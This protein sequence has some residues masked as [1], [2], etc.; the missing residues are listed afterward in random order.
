MI[1]K[2]RAKTRKRIS[3]P[4]NINVEHHSCKERLK[5]LWPLPLIPFRIVV[6]RYPHAS[7]FWK[8]CYKY[9]NI[10]YC[11]WGELL[12]F[13]CMTSIVRSDIH[14]KGVSGR[15]YY[16][17][18]ISNNAKRITWKLAAK[19]IRFN[20]IGIFWGFSQ[21]SRLYQLTCNVGA[22]KRLHPPSYMKCHRKWP[23]MQQ[24][25]QND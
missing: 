21:D 22:P 14:L 2:N 20:A 25:L 13:K 17:A 6:D 7:S 16:K 23:R 19:M 24:L 12:Q 9:R 3:L 8:E 5:Y 10:E 18:H 11:Y 15:R 1:V 4:E